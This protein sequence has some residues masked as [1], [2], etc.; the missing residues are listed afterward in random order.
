MASP[1]DY[2]NAIEMIEEYL[3]EPADSLDAEKTKHVQVESDLERILGEVRW[4]VQNLKH[5][6]QMKGVGKTMAGSPLVTGHTDDETENPWSY[7]DDY[8]LT[9]KPESIKAA[10]R[11]RDELI[12]ELDWMVASGQVAVTARLVAFAKDINQERNEGD[13][14]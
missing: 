13:S 11:H 5:H 3:N 12:A 14:R 7:S 4:D 1:S 9:G 6:L 10:D 8:V 2:A